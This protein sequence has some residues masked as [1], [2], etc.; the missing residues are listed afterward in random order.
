MSD[1]NPLLPVFDT[2]KDL[3]HKLEA[4]LSSTNKDSLM[5]LV[6]KDVMYRMIGGGL[7]GFNYETGAYNFQG[8]LLADFTTGVQVINESL[9]EFF[10]V[11]KE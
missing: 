8:V 10:I 7:L 5:I 6:R 4:A 2:A 1:S 11:T 3:Y 9:P